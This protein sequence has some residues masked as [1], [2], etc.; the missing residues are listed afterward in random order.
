MICKNC[1]M[2]VPEI[3]D[4]CPVCG[5]AMRGK[6]PDFTIDNNT[7]QATP[8]IAPQPVYMAA[9]PQVSPVEHQT[10]PR[11]K[12]F[13]KNKKA[14]IIVSVSLL[15]VVLTAIIVPVVL[16]NAKMTKYN[17]AIVLLENGDYTG[18][19]V[20]FAELKSFEDAPE[21]IEHCEIAEDYQAAKQSLDNGDYEKALA[22]F[23]ALGGFEDAPE[24]AAYC[25][26]AIAYEKAEQ[27]L[28]QEL[29]ADAAKAFALLGNF[30]DAAQQ[31]AHCSNTVIYLQA[32][33]LFESADYLA[34]K[35]LYYKLPTD[36]FP[37]ATEK[38]AFCV[39]KVNYAVAEEYYEQGAY[40]DAYLAF[41]ELGSFDDADERM[42]TCVQSFPSTGESYRNQD[43]KNSNL[44]LAIVP[45]KSDGSRNYI[46]IYTADNVLVSCITIAEGGEATV[47]LP[48]GSYRIKA[49]YGYGDWF[50]ETDM[51]G[52]DGYYS[53]L[54][55]GVGDNELFSLE[56]NNS[57]TLTLRGDLDTS[58]DPV[59]LERENRRDF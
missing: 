25:E 52:E 18:A 58:G 38:H 31:A 22:A 2:Q 33:E 53:V 15:L 36:S 29:Y 48:Q 13:F 16:H 54:T 39:N 35:D 55:N 50:G 57:Y 9:P 21:M 1:G 28:S 20:L 17:H 3:E 23:L 44:S 14:V 41:K 19:K 8:Y 4:Y 37:D 32:E 26:N 10:T 11:K 27:L 51:F 12:E 42:S 46:K 24:Q 7:A 47:S 59:N 40:Y 49:A 56:S 30:R 34:A 45:P 43:Y 5:N 6:T